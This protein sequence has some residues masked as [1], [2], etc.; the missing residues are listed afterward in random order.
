M[1][2]MTLLRNTRPRVS[3]YIAWLQYARHWSWRETSSTTKSFQTPALYMYRTPLA[4]YKPD[5]RTC[6]VIAAFE[7]VESTRRLRWVLLT[8]WEF[9][10]TR[11]DIYG[12]ISHEPPASP[13]NS[14]VS[15]KPSSPHSQ[16]REIIPKTQTP[17]LESQ[18][19]SKCLRVRL[20]NSQIPLRRY[21]STEYVIALHSPSAL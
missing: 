8:A 18:I 13:T 12:E 7:C 6:L 1:D 4:G 10:E 20:W 2:H 16:V 15:F 5:N 11:H 3:I 14:R 17:K 19:T 9:V 21:P